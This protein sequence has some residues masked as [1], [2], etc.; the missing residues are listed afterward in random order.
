MRFFPDSSIRQST[1]AE[2]GLKLKEKK[3][4]REKFTED[5][6]LY[7][8]NELSAQDREEFENA[9]MQDDR[10][11]IEFEKIKTD[12]A[13]FIQSKPEEINETMLNSARNNLIRELR[14]EPNTSSLF[15]QMID[16]LKIFFHQNY[17]LAYGGLV[18]FALGIGIGY[19]LLFSRSAQ[20]SL[21]LDSPVEITT[22]DQTQQNNS[23]STSQSGNEQILEN[24]IS[25]S[26]INS[27][28]LNSQKFREALIQALIGGSNPGIRIQSISKISDQVKEESFK[29]DTKIKQALLTALMKDE[30]PAVRREAL[31]ALQRYPFDNQ[32]RDALLHVLSTDKNSG[33]R[34]TAIN[35]LA[36]WNQQHK[37]IDEVLKQALTKKAQADKNT[38]VQIRA[39]SIL[40]EVE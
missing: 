7:L 8:L 9:L 24:K 5:A 15:S 36:D 4:N 2:S 30:N 37:I 13:L 28:N 10:L 26:A 3:M 35:A 27:N 32:I 17:G 20:N 16:K 21:T 14:K 22:S 33:L 23:G 25:E 11:K 38:F 39:A 19:M 12:R 6:F 34:V 29:L 31:L 18:T 40:K 1:D